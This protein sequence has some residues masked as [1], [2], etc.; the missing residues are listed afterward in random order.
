MNMH[1][2]EAIIASRSYPALSAIDLARAILTHLRADAEE[3]TPDEIHEAIALLCRQRFPY[4]DEPV[5]R[6]ALDI[7]NHRLKIDPAHAPQTGEDALRQIEAIDITGLDM[8]DVDNSAPRFEWVNP[9]EIFVDPNY[10][11]SISDRGRRLIRRIIERFDWNRYSPPKCAYALFEGKRI[12]KCVDGQHTSIAAASRPDIE[13]IPV[14]IIVAP[15]MHQQADAFVGQNTQRVSVS[16]L[17]LH[18]S[19][20]AANDVEA[21]TIQ[22]I[23]DA[24]GI[25]ILRGSSPRYECGDTTA[26]GTIYSMLNKH[27]LAKTKAILRCLAKAK[28]APIDENHLKAATS[29]F[30]DLEYRDTFEPDDLAEA[31]F[32]Q[33]LVDKDEAQALVIAKKIPF[34]RCLASVWYR[35]TKK[36]RKPRRAS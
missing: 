4:V 18:A 17:Q 30:T 11:R 1:S 12:L 15:E 31:I 27:G 7:V 3:R 16:K 26:V 28:L 25:T 21:M 8:V 29:L 14:M 35:K 20:L 19:S 9:R 22:G 2:S 13:K 5:L 23:C 36:K 6:E 10:Q 33:S 24:V 32:G 34:W